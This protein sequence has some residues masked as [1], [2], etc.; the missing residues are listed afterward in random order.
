[1]GFSFHP[2]GYRPDA[3]CV[4]LGD[5]VGEFGELAPE[6][7][8]LPGD[9]GAGTEGPRARRYGSPLV[10]PGVHRFRKNSSRELVR[11]GAILEDGEN[12]PR[13]GIVGRV[14]QQ[15]DE[16]REV[17]RERFRALSVDVEEHVARPLCLPPGAARRELEDSRER[18]LRVAHLARQCLPVGTVPEFGGIDGHGDP[19][20]GVKKRSPAKNGVGTDLP[21]MAKIDLNKL[22]T[23]P[24]EGADKTRSRKQAKAYAAEIADYVDQFGAVKSHAMLVIFQGMDASGKNGAVEAAFEQTS[25]LNLRV[26]SFKKP[27]EEEAAHDFLWRAHAHAPAKGQVAIWNRS[28]YE[29]VLIQRV[30]GWIDNERVS[31]RFRAINAFERLLIEDNDTIVLKFLLHIGKDEQEKQLQERLDEPDKHYKHNPGDWE[32]RKHWDEYMAAYNDVLARSE[33]P[34]AIVPTDSRWYRDILVAKAVMDAFEG[35]NME[36]P[37]L[38]VE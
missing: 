18:H 24:P 35:L 12:L 26:H 5:R 6:S 22:P 36:W 7:L 15:R 17:G 30:H 38:D 11:D 25:P 34:W 27:T 21:H 14:L 9:V 29:D 1:M 10:E 2:P 32:E 23:T 28:H 37:A 20:C 4:V 16:G 3:G 31:E 13:D 33:V 19:L 8:V